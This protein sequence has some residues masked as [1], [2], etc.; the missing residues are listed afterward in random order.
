[1]V[2]TV[3]QVRVTFGTPCLLSRVRTDP[4]FA[5]RTFADAAAAFLARAERWA[6]GVIASGVPL[7]LF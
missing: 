4:T 3:F 1:M 6:R 5:L 7:A 2:M